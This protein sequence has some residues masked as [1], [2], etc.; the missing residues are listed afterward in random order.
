M[1]YAYVSYATAY[2][3]AN[4]PVEFTASLLTSV[5]GDADR[6]GLYMKSAMESGVSIK[7]PSINISTDSFVPD[8]NFIRFG[9]SAI[10]GVGDKAYEAIMED[11]RKNGPYKSFEDF[12]L[13]VYGGPVNK[14]VLESLVK[15]GAFDEFGLSRA[16]M[17]NA[18]EPVIKAFN[19]YKG[20]IQRIEKRYETIF[21]WDDVAK[22]QKE[23]RSWKNG[24][25]TLTR[26]LS[27]RFQTLFLP[28]CL[29]GPYPKSRN[30]S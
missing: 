11:R 28:M 3:K 7:P 13:R 15:S 16:Q 24:A 12:L 22:L 25:P 30:M 6:V 19:S 26:T 20:K 29:N 18:I 5:K 21:E 8:G 14:T 4:Y 23:R 2:L 17:F 1:S 27:P 10:K 9:L